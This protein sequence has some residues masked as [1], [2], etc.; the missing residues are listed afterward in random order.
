MLTQDTV[1][2]LFGSLNTSKDAT[3]AKT[4]SKL[5]GKIGAIVVTGRGQQTR[6]EAI[7]QIYQAVRAVSKLSTA[8][9][10]GRKPKAEVEGKVP[11]KRG[12][13]KIVR[14]EYAA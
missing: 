12:R 7:M 6:D 3:I 13:P 5:A 8:K 11:K 2:D 4:A 9:K 1:N 10:P 14:E